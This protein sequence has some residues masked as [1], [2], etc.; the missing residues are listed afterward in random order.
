MYT[1]IVYNRFLITELNR[2]E[3]LISIAVQFD[4]N[5]LD[6]LTI[7]ASVSVDGV[8]LTVAKIIDHNV[9]FDIMQATLDQTTLKNLQIGSQVNIERSSKFGDEIG[10]HPLSGH[11]DGKAELVKLERPEDNCILTFKAPEKLLPYLFEKAYLGLHGASLTL[12]YLNESL[13]EF[14]VYLIPETLR[15]TNLGDLKVGD[16]VNLEIDR[17]T[18]VIVDTINRAM[19]RSVQ[20]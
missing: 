1:G 17:Q 5:Y 20:K 11:I 18:Q 3:G 6:K 4:A 10:G 16:F 13:C 19:A 7:G 15:R 12:A 8:C 14:Q 9:Y 2:K